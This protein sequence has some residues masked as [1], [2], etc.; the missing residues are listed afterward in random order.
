MFSANIT[1]ISVSDFGINAFMNTSD[2]VFKFTVI[3]FPLNFFRVFLQQM[4]GHLEIGWPTSTL[5]GIEVA[6]ATLQELGWLNF[7]LPEH[8]DVKIVFTHVSFPTD[9]AGKSLSFMLCI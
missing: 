7:V 4:D 2:K 6:Y 5:H 3:F 9:I 1:E 8:M